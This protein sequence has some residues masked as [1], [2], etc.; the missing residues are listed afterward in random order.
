MFDI[1]REAEALAQA[2]NDQ[3]RLGRVA[4]LLTH[5][6]WA[7]RDLVH[8]L[9]TGHRVLDL[10]TTS[11]DVNRQVMACFVL[12][13]VYYDLGA[14]RQ[15]MDMLWR[16]V[17]ALGHAGPQERFGEP[18]LGP[19]LQSVA[20]CRWLI[21]ALADMGA[22]AK[23]LAIAEDTIRLAEADGHPYPLVLAYTGVGCR[24]LGKGESTRPAL[25]IAWVSEV[26]VRAGHVADAHALAVQA[27]AVTQEHKEHGTEAWTL[28]LLGD[29]AMHCHPPEAESAANHYQ[30]A[31][32][33][34]KEPGM[35]PLQVH[36]HLGLGTLYG[37]TD[38]RSKL[39]PNWSLPLHYTALWT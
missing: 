6:L 19:G 11:R 21:Q 27:L 31:L 34:A 20:S 13:E 26:C 5:Y 39:V 37:R 33:L 36:C 2:L 17:E 12:G 18:A 29:I 28:R 9:V 32:P 4:V 22:F 14:Y 16:N 24:Y 10:A 7:G 3:R 25:Y 15:A 38:C 23:G 8:A 35:R 30:Q 1:L